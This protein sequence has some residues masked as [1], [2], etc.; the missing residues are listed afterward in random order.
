[1]ATYVLVPGGAHGGWCYQ[2]VARL[3]RAEGHEVYALTL[4]GVGERSHL[5]GPDIDLDTHIT[6]VVAV[7]AVGEPS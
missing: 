6:D 3:L 1:M 5:L 4:T 7:L 2:P